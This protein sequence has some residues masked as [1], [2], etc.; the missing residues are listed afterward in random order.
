VANRATEKEKH[1][2]KT[3]KKGDRVAAGKSGSED[4]DEGRVMSVD[5]TAKIA[6]VAWDSLVVTPAP[7]DILMVEKPTSRRRTR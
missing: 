3:V 5:R 4:Y 2:A 6:M 1:M 7:F